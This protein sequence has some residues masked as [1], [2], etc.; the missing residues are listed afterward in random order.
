ME[1]QSCSTDMN[2]Q[3]LCNVLTWFFLLKEQAVKIWLFNDS[4]IRAPISSSRS[5]S[6]ILFSSVNPESKHISFAGKFKGMCNR[7]TKTESWRNNHNLFACAHVLLLCGFQRNCSQMLSPASH[8]W[9]SIDTKKKLLW[10]HWN[11]TFVLTFLLIR[12]EIYEKKKNVF[13]KTLS[14]WK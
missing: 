13:M 4:W 5:Q 3:R 11:L 2:E 9:P 12:L 6:T 7:E 10:I 8:Q 1:T 14:C